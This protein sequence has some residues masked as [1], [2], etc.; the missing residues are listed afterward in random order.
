MSQSEAAHEGFG[1]GYHPKFAS[2]K[3]NACPFPISLLYEESFL[4]SLFAE[5]F[6]LLG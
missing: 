3:R 4:A 1:T 6:H 5:S 2:L